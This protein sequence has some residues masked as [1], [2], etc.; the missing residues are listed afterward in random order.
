MVRDKYWDHLKKSRDFLAMG[1]PLNTKDC[2]PQYDWQ[3]AVYPTCNSL[4]ELD[5]ATLFDPQKKE[6]VKIIAHGCEYM[7]LKR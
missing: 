2:K 1:E 7:H 5:I 6:R 4:H 3:G